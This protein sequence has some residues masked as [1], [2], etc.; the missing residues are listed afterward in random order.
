M[1]IQINPTFKSLIPAL[2]AEEYSQLEQNIVNDGCRE[3]LILWGDVLID[4][5]NRFEICTNNEIEFKAVRKEF[6]DENAAINWMIDNQLG[7][8]NISPQQRDYLIGKRYKGEKKQVGEHKGNQ[9]NNLE[10]A[11]NE[12]I[13]T[14]D[15]I[16]K[17]NNVSRET[18]K[19]AEKF[20]DGVDK[21]ATVNPELKEEILSGSS[22]YT[23][24]EIIEIAKID[25][26]EE[27]K[28][29]L[30]EIEEERKRT[31]QEKKQKMQDYIEAQKE[32][33]ENGIAV[34]PEGKFEVINI[35]PPW[36]YGTKYDPDGRRV[37][38]PYP[39]M[40]QQ[41]LLKMEIPSADDSV[42]FL[43]TTQRFIWDAKELLD[44]WGFTYRNM[45]VWDKEKIGMGDLFR[46]QCEFCIVGIK[47]KPLFD[48]DHTNRDIIKESR[49]EHSRKPES[50]YDMVEKLCV[51]RKLDYFSRE[52]RQGW[53]VFGNDTKKY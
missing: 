16:A 26:E 10:I 2:S 11:Q 1:N 21:I 24:K 35:D 53:E 6:S 47:G 42:M 4:G 15:I 43:W 49:R 38:N 23:K 28:K 14:A 36:N 34:L 7:R 29:R 25:V 13:P 44:N 19:R 22:D 52:C 40:S 41:E 30:E 27:V 48:N 8:R 31:K 37:A 9:Y 5:H 45:I 20:A 32:A 12:P 33:I 46:M 18:V 50:F 3:P 17:Q 39:E 51:G